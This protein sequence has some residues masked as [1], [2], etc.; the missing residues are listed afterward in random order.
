[1]KSQPRPPS[2]MD[3]KPVTAY[4]TKDLHRE[5]R[6]LGIELEKSSQEMLTEALKAYLK[7]HKR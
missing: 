6:M 2:R 7:R 4:V 3:K 1:M 5:L